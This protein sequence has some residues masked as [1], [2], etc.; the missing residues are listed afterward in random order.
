LKNVKVSKLDDTV[1]RLNYLYT[2]SLI[3]FFVFSIGLQQT[4]SEPLSCKPEANYPESWVKYVNNYCYVNGTFGTRNNTDYKDHQPRDYVEYYQWVPYILAGQALSFYLP[5]LVYLFLARWST[6]LNVRQIVDR[7]NEVSGKKRSEVTEE[8][9]DIAHSIFDFTTVP[10]GSNEKQPRK[11]A[12]LG[13]LL[14][15]SYLFS[16]LLNLLNILANLWLLKVLVGDGN[17][18]WAFSIVKNASNN[19]FWETTGYFPRI[20]FCEIMFKGLGQPRTHQIQ[21][22][23]MINILIEKVFVMIH[24]WLLW[25]AVVTAYNFLTTFHELLVD[26]K[27]KVRS[28]SEPYFDDDRKQFSDFWNKYLS[29][30]GLLIIRF[31]EEHAGTVVASKLVK[32]LSELWSKRAQNQLTNDV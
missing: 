22:L 10:Y 18:N 25:L 26:G 15:Y 31:V 5:H 32:E 28:L 23:L 3:V 24:F 13:N 7:C 12:S 29:N 1:D 4:F 20:T 14:A 16:K 2:T 9:K 27:P 11:P 21:C 6:G 8:V 17:W 30:N 19:V